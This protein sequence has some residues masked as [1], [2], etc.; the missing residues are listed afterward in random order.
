MLAVGRRVPDRPS[1]AAAATPRRRTSRS[2]RSRSRPRSSSPSRRWSPGGST[3]FDPAVVTVAQIEAGTTHNI[4]PESAM[5]YGTI[6][7]VSPERSRDR[8]RRAGVHGRRAGATAR[9][10]R[11]SSIAG[12]SGDDQRPRLAALG[13]RVAAELIGAEQVVADWPRRSW[14][15]RTSRTSSS[16][17]PG[18][19][20]FLGAP[21]RRGPGDR[22]AEPLQSHG[23]R[24]GGAPGRG[25]AV[26]RGGAR[27][28]LRAGAR[29]RPYGTTALL[30]VA[31][32]VFQAAWVFVLNFSP[33]T[34]SRCPSR[35][36]ARGE[37]VPPSPL[38]GNDVSHGPPDD[39]QSGCSPG[40]TCG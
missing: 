26:H 24:R 33:R 23:L 31:S 2:T 13:P 14:A 9:P 35:C 32:A 25:R 12:L 11:S 21:A 40:D 39:P 38:V 1:A 37:S 4:I 5:L 36:R 19:M 10:P 15:R 8:G 20:A 34:C 27:S 6:R 16:A 7:T 18:A 28:A 3:S 30:V 29:V 17:C 22:A